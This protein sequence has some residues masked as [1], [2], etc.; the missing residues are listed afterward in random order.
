VTNEPTP[1][2]PAD[3]PEALPP[4][5]PPTAERPK[6]YRAPAKDPL[7]QIADAIREITP[8][9]DAADMEPD[10]TRDDWSRSRGQI[11]A[12]HALFKGEILPVIDEGLRSLPSGNELRLKI[13]ANVAWIGAELAAL[14]WASKKVDD[15]QRLLLQVVKIAPSSAPDGANVKAELEGALADTA[16]WVE[17]IRARYLQRSRQWEEGDRVLRAVRSKATHP[18]IKAAIAKQLGGARP[19]TGGPPPLFRINGCGASIYGERDRRPDGSYVTTYC[20]ALLFIPVWPISAYRV[21]DQGNGSYG[22]M[23]KE[24]LSAF[25]RGYR[26]VLAGLVGVWIAG[27]VFT[28]WLSDPHRLATNAFE[29]TRAEVASL[30]GPAALAA[31]ESLA[32]SHGYSLSGEARD[33]TGTEIVRLTLDQVATP[34]TAARVGEVEAAIARFRAMP[35][36]ARGPAQQRLL[37]E[38]VLAWQSE[39]GSAS[40]EDTLASMRILD[41]LEAASAPTS[42]FPE[43][44]EVE[45]F[46]AS[47]G[48]RGAAAPSPELAERRAGLH[49]VLG[50]QLASDWPLEAVDH[51]VAAGDPQSIE[52]A[53]TTLAELAPS[54]SLLLEIERPVSSYLAAT[55]SGTEPRDTV[56]IAL[57]AARA[58]Q[59]DE[60]RR[61]ALESGDEQAL[62][63]VLTT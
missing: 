11:D 49:R 14:L 59:A 37:T 4:L 3:A 50:E 28:S 63:A 35:E 52:R 42:Q 55:S 29:D 12:A 25:A 13:S 10:P 34:M 26:W 6:A 48:Q 60:G 36:L 20:V 41:A 32:S 30:D 27:A 16:S 22:F 44:A 1:P 33:V 17:L 47:Q 51:W 24:P 58:M 54:R 9:L 31:W 61:L 45:A 7:A 23:A 5:D 62:R 19:M 39:V 38:R 15:A 46:L 53:G 56:A 57:E 40:H 18:V 43:L 2:D 21:I 8:V